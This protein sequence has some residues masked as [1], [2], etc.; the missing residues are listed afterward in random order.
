MGP[1]HAD[2]KIMSAALET[3]WASAEI[4]SQLK[5]KRNKVGKYLI[6]VGNWRDAWRSLQNRPY[7]FSCQIFIR[8][9]K[10]KKN[11]ENDDNN[12]LNEITNCLV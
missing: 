11:H 7:R 9:K 2:R 1:E 10:K 3:A 12:K 8:E 5:G 4:Q 6:S